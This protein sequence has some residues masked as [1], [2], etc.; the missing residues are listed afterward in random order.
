MELKRSLRSLTNIFV[1]FSVYLCKQWQELAIL[2]DHS[3]MA[4]GVRF[5]RDA[6]FL[7]STSMDRSLKVYGMNVNVA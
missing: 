5:G 3:D 1:T 2:T 6:Q 4:T 7:A